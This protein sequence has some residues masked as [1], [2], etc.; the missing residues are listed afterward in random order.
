MEPAD[1][2][3]HQE[4]VS[5]KKL[6]KG[7]GRTSTRKTVLG[8]DINTCQL[9]IHLTKRHHQ[10]LLDILNDILWTQK[11]ISVD[12]WHKVLGE[13][14]SMLLAL[15][16]SRG[17]Y[18]TLQ[19][20]FKSDKKH[21]HLTTMVHDFLDNFWWITRSLHNRPTCVYEVVPASPMIVASTDALG[22]GMGGTYF[23]PTPWS[24]TERPNYYPYGHRM[25]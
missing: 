10:H 19:V 21:I 14:Q 4:P 17:L 22:L 8:W 9:T 1:P 16:G 23:I 25:P 6:D 2:P 11:R 3:E 18:S 15:P 5:L 20:H 24:T 13:V 12:T 7:D